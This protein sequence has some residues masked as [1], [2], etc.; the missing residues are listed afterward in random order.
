MSQTASGQWQGTLTSVTVGGTVYGAREVLGAKRAGRGVRLLLST[1]DPSG[2]RL[3]ATVAPGKGG[4]LRVDA[5]PE[6]PSGVATM[7]DSFVSSAGEAF[8]GFGGRHNAIDQRG[9]EFYNYLQ[10]ENISSGIAD[11][12]TSVLPTGP[13][14]LFPNGEAAAYYVQ[15]SFVSS[16]GY[17]FLLDRDEISEWRLASDRAD[18]WQVESFGP[19]LEY[20]VAPGDAPDAIGKLT[21]LTGRHRLPPNWA[22]G[23]ILDRAVQ[24]LGESPAD[25]A[26]A[27]ADDIANIDRY[28][29]PLDA[30]RIE[31]WQFIPRDV[32]A[33][34]IAELKQRGIHP[35]LY[36]RAFVGRDTIGTDS[37]AAFDEALANGYVATH[38]DG[39]PYVFGSNFNADGAQIDF[40]NPDAVRWWQQRVTEALELGADGFM[41]DFGE[42]VFED[43]RFDDG[44]TGATMHNRLPVLFHR[45]TMEA[46]RRFER[47]HP[48][49][50]IFYFTRSGYS[51][52]PGSAGSEFANFPGDETT[53]WTRSSGLASLTPDMLNRAIGGAYGFTTDIGGFFDVGPYLPTTKELF[54]RWA[55]WAA[56]SPF[57]RLHGSVLGGVHTPWSYDDETVAIYERLSRL[58]LAA[59]PLIRRLWKR[60]ER[61]GIPITRPLWLAYPS[62]PAA[63][64]EDQEWLLGPKVL[65][66]PVVEQ[67]ADSREVYFPEGCWRSP[68]TG[69]RVSGPVRRRVDVPIDRLAYFFRCRAEAVRPAGERVGCRHHDGN[70]VLRAGLRR[71]RVERARALQ[72]RR[73]R[74]RQ[75]RP[76]DKLAMVWE[77]FDGATREVEW[78]ELQDLSNQ[79]AHLLARARRRARRP[80]R[81]RPPADARDRGDLL[82]HLEARRDPALDVGPL[83]RRRHPPPPRGL[84]AEAC[85]SP[86]PPTRRASTP[87]S[88]TRSSSST[89]RRCS[90]APRPTTICED[91]AADDPA[92]LYYTSGT[93]GMAKGIVHAHR[94]ILAHEE[95]VYC[96]DVQ[97]GERFHGMGEWAWA[98]GHLAAARPVA[99]RRGPVRLPARGRLRPRRAARL[100]LPPRGHERLHDADGDAGDDGDRGRRR[101]ATRRS[102]GSS[103]RPASRSTPRRSAGSASSTGSP[104]STTTGSPS[105]IRCARTSRSWRSARARWAGRCP[106]GTSRSSTRTRTPSPR[107]SAARSACAPARTRTTRSATGATPEAER[108]D[109]RR[110]VVPLQGRRD[111][112]R[113]RIRLVRRP[114]R[115]RD[116]RR[117]LP[118]RP[119]RGRVRLPRARRRRRGRRRRLARRGQGQR[120]QGV[121]RP[122]RGPRGH[123]TSSPTRSRASSASG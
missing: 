11:G 6:D 5:R 13:E 102:S 82:R 32:L 56:L 42:Q 28:G 66:A 80:R 74:L 114:R 111:A 23:T 52:T 110:R 77:R 119:V 16:A 116:H 7:L 73:R 115:R 90:P 122:R 22:L 25:Y 54:L 62:D 2:R 45:A 87:R 30:Y 93:T 3:I 18:A 100:P 24:Y 50:R 65:V 19:R 94:Y 46:V 108:G 81:R 123:P 95:F 59:R 34:L 63:A 106:A 121:H 105:P 72:H 9:N 15:S 68:E 55:E 8:H 37:P 71:A 38:A 10:Q 43:M 57:F 88:S 103:A 109:V 61:T 117:R 14:F 76:R 60:A 83:R 21:A 101:D 98:A 113:G 4:T 97:D 79:A 64:A 89:T 112:G 36:F 58:H 49:R 48:G 96:H 104:S 70:R 85:S 51:G 78:G 31:G 47:R 67:G 120:R 26:A 99:A 29:L 27:V 35:M 92:Q 39:S 84:G 41:Q 1:S 69:L 33:G 44:S 17:G 20:V 118:D 107:A 75:A 12:I 40:T 91:T 86:T 53:D